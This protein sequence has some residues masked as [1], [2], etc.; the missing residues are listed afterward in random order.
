MH[1]NLTC[2]F[3]MNF[4]GRTTQS[5]TFLCP[6]CFIT[7][8]DTSL[9]CATQGF[10]AREHFR[11]TGRQLCSLPFQD[12]Q[13]FLSHQIAQI[14]GLN[15]RARNDSGWKVAWSSSMCCEGDFDLRWNMMSKGA[16]L[17]NGNCF[18]F[19]INF[20]ETSILYINPVVGSLQY[21]H[22]RLSTSLTMWNM[23]PSG[24]RELNRH[25]DSHSLILLNHVL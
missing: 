15:T 23:S 17:Q 2:R 20:I 11:G 14:C 13:G 18:L 21:V 1:Y 10:N 12:G 9:C 7:A 25:F 16:S 22:T 3:G 8:Q 4:L 5:F 19:C 6:A 24:T